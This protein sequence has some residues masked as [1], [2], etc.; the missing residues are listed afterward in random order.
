M[1]FEISNHHRRSSNLLSIT[2][3]IILIK[4]LFWDFQLPLAQATSYLQF[5]VT[6]C[7]Y[8]WCYWT[9]M[10]SCQI[11]WIILFWNIFKYSY[12]ILYFYK[13]ILII[14]YS[15]YQISHFTC[16]ACFCPFNMFLPIFV[17]NIDALLQ[18]CNMKYH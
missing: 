6:K 5:G 3:L 2:L 18:S 15:F 4:A 14:P 16:C 1:I 12:Y 9:F 10:I 17:L 13:Y 11:P 8:L 7:Q